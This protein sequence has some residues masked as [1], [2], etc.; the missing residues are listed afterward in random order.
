M[1]EHVCKKCGKKFEH[2]AAVDNMLA[3]LCGECHIVVYP[4]EERRRS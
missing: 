1:P 3:S 2:W 4:L